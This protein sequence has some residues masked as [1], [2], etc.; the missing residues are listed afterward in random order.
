M[1][2]PSTMGPPPADC[3]DCPPF[4]ASAQLQ[5]SPMWATN[6]LCC[7]PPTAPDSTWGAQSFQPTARAVPSMT[8]LLRRLE[9]FP[10][11]DE[12]VLRFFRG[13]PP[14]FS[15][16]TMAYDALPATP[17]AAVML[18][19]KLPPPL[20]LSRAPASALSSHRAAPSSSWPPA[21]IASI[22]SCSLRSTLSADAAGNID[23]PLHGT[24]C[25]ST[26]RPA[27]DGGARD[28]ARGTFQSSG[29][30]AP[31]SVPAGSALQQVGAR[32]P[33]D[34][35][36]NGKGFSPDSSDGDGGGADDEENSSSSESSDG[37]EEPVSR[38]GRAAL[39]CNV[40]ADAL[41]STAN[42]RVDKDR[43]RKVRLFL[44]QR[45]WLSLSSMSLPGAISAP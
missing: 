35:H 20:S 30:L 45:C 13:L 41:P 25:P 2:Q 38:V 10:L 15:P 23:P 6:L 43:W 40:L 3:R 36:D 39:V 8:S 16:T 33:A 31:R 5:T 34:S 7:G 32:P 4:I 19:R 28:E 24:A 17:P 37:D 18:Q 27:A 22:A 42:E 29:A 14:F 21:A 1:P 44:C 9:A 26:R 11:T 12:P